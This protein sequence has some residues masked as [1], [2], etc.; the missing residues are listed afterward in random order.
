MNPDSCWRPASDP[1]RAPAFSPRVSPI[2]VTRSTSLPMGAARLFW[3][4]ARSRWQTASKPCAGMKYGTTGSSRS[5]A[6]RMSASSRGTGNE[7]EIVTTSVQEAHR[8]N[9]EY[10]ARSLEF[11]RDVVEREMQYQKDRPFDIRKQ[12]VPALLRYDVN[13]LIH[14]VFLEE[15]AGVIR[16]QRSLS[17]F[18]EADGATVAVSGGVKFNRVDPSLKERR[19]A[20]ER[21]LPPGRV[22]GRAHHGLLQPRPPADPRVRPRSRRGASLGPSGAL[23]DSA[24][25]R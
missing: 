17:A 2:W 22:D 21:P 7:E 5:G 16:L 13:S 19:R 20:S 6:C 14:G 24:D 18:V 11:K 9:S 3:W 12:L 8:I 23:Q 10:I 25:P 4:K 1:S 15:I